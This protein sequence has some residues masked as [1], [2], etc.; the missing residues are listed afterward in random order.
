MEHWST[1]GFE[2]GDLVDEGDSIVV[3]QGGAIREVL[4]G[5]SFHAL[6]LV[7]GGLDWGIQYGRKA[8]YSVEMS[9]PAKAKSQSCFAQVLGDVRPCLRP[10]FV[11]YSTQLGP[12]SAV[13]V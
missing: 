11:R 8:Y 7:C 13:A 6:R 2:L 10:H 5:V 3:V 1:V 12:P 4:D 9:A